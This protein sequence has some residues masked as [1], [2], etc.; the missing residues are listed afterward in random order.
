MKERLNGKN[1]L[2]KFILY[3]VSTA[4]KLAI[5]STLNIKKINSVDC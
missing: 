2:S 4:Q 3:K 1:F 5:K